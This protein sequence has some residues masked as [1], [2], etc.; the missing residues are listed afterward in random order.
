VNWGPWHALLLSRLTADGACC[1]ALQF[2][3]NVMLL[4]IMIAI[5]TSSFNKVTQDEGPRFNLSKVCRAPLQLEHHF[6][7]SLLKV[8]GCRACVTYWNQPGLSVTLCKHVQ[9]VQ[10]VYPG[11][12]WLSR[13]ALSCSWL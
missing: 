12:V 10:F 2:V 13:A 11:S 8:W 9:Q 4:N 3:C 1:T 6:L 5:M 7:L